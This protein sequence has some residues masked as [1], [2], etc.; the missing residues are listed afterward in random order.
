MRQLLP[1]LTAFALLLVLSTAGWSA[2]FRKGMDA[3]KSGD[4][5]TAL[6]VLKPLAERGNP[7]TQSILAR[8][9]LWGQGVSQDY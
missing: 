5:A 4:Y 9:Y 8:L 7:E 3:Y 6:R 1:A 2:D